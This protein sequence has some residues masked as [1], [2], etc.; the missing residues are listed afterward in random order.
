M[1]KTEKREIIS[2]IKTRDPKTKKQKT[3]S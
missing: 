2:E 1:L 3:A